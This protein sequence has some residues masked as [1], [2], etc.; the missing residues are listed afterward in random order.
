MI[1]AEASV[2]L[3]F[4]T[5]LASS[6]K[7]SFVSACE[8]T[9]VFILVLGFSSIATLSSLELMVSLRTMSDPK[10]LL[11]GISESYMSS[12]KLLLTDAL[13]ADLFRLTILTIYG[14]FNFGSSESIEPFLFENLNSSGYKTFCSL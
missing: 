8:S 7:F 2:V 14:S 13:S 9:F 3:A 10:D 5:G 4:S 12:T 11:R 1:V 6:C